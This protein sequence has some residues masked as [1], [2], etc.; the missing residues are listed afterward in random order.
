MVWI[1]VPAKLGQHADYYC[2]SETEERSWERPQDQDV[3][4]VAVFTP[5]NRCYYWNTKTGKVTWEIPMSDKDNCA[6][7]TRITSVEVVSEISNQLSFI[8]TKE[9]IHQSIEDWRFQTLFKG[10][11]LDNK[12]YLYHQNVV[13]DTFSPNNEE[14]IAVAA[15]DK[16]VYYWDYVGRRTVNDLPAEARIIGRVYQNAVKEWYFVDADDGPATWTLPG[17]FDNQSNQDQASKPG[18]F[19]WWCK[20]GAAVTLKELP[21]IQFNNHIA[22]VISCNDNEILVQLPDCLAAVLSVPLQCTCPLE[23][24]A[25]VE[26]TGLQ[27]VH[28]LNGQIGRVESFDSVKQRYS[29]RLFFNDRAYSIQGTKLKARSKLWN[30]NLQNRHIEL[31]WKK[32]QTCLFI[33]ATGNQQQFSIHLP[34]GFAGKSVESQSQSIRQWPLLLYLH[35]SCRKTFFGHS[36]KAIR[37]NG[38]KYAAQNFV[39]V[40]PHCNWNWR[41]QPKNW[42]IDL[43]LELRAA[44]WIDPRRIYVT[45]CSMGGMGTW[46]IGAT[47]P[48]LFA[49]V[50]P[51]AAHHHIERRENIAGQLC[52]TPIFVAHYF[53][54]TCCP[55]KDEEPLWCL[56]EYSN[57]LFQLNMAYDSDHCSIFD[58][59][60]CDS[61][62]LFEWLLMF[63]KQL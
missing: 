21:Q 38:Q 26:L 34:L 56:L 46:E 52:R 61:I 27:Q 49:A 43:V 32:E 14:W 40:S 35:G 6:A 55:T 10:Y 2:N 19:M 12:E 24:Y 57:P 60:Y 22:Q 3:A 47:R 41:E 59:A 30:L 48:D 4:W 25:I 18:D 50:A 9:Q 33:D 7:P 45:G 31:Q 16:S 39:V 23:N 53:H 44:S 36:K 13:E 20:A 11:A 62:N 37:S 58:H 28:A 29:V 54:D 15:E 63:E 5:E 8:R 17:L 42:V 1:K 51:V